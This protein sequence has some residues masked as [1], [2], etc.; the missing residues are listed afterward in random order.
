MPRGFRQVKMPSKY[1]KKRPFTPG[2][3]D[4]HYQRPSGKAPTPKES[5]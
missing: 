2:G 4:K 3:G 1:E 5:R